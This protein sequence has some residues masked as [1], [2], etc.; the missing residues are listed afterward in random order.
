[1]L[2]YSPWILH[3]NMKKNIHPFYNAKFIFHTNGSAFLQGVPIKNKSSLKNALTNSCSLEGHKNTWLKKYHPNT[4]H[5]WFDNN[6]SIKNQDLVY[7]APTFEIKYFLNIKQNQDYKFGVQVLN[8]DT[9]THQVWVRKK[10]SANQNVETPLSKF[11]LK[12][13]I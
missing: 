9:Y 1:M 10:I 5:L 7:L 6:V 12:Y 3:L 11:K 2:K 4:S 8:V 13:N